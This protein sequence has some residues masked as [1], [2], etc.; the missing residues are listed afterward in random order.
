MITTLGLQPQFIVL[1]IVFF[2]LLI[3]TAVIIPIWIKLYRNNNY[4]TD[5]LLWISGIIGWIVP[6]SLIFVGIGW[7]S[8]AFPENPKYWHFY[9]VQGTISSVT[10]QFSDG[11]GALTDGDYVIKFTGSNHPYVISDDRIINLKGDNASLLCTIDWVDYG[12]SADYWECNIR[13]VPSVGIG[14]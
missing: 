7:Y 9:E 8:A 13:S 4:D 2:G 3:L 11:S 6:I 5:S 10:N 14:Q 12:N 1:P